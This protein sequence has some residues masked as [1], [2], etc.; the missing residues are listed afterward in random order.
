MP[1]Y[2][3]Q[4][5]YVIEHELGP[6]K[7]GRARNPEQRLGELQVSSPFELRLKKT[8]TPDDAAA[9]EKY[10]HSHFDKYHMRGE[11]FDI[12]ADERDFPIP[13]RISGNQPD[14]D[15]G[16]SIDRDMDE[17]WARTLD[18]LFTAMKVTRYETSDIRSLRSRI[19]ELADLE[20]DDDESRNAG[21]GDVLEVQDDTPSDKIRCPQCGHRYDQGELGCPT[22]GGQAVTD[23]RRR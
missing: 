3:P 22:C 10:L 13:R 6:V 7:I 21:P 11:W 14:V 15:L 12:P 23:H 4:Q 2:G 19:R 8:A 18:R 17:S 1:S 9:V 20:V 16:L 5:V